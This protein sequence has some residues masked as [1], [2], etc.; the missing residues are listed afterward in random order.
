MTLTPEQIQANRK[1]A[2]NLA[3]TQ[4]GLIDKAKVDWSYDERTNYNKALAKIIKDSPTSFATQDVA[5]ASQVERADYSPLASADFS[6]S[7]F[8]SAV[9]DNVVDA[10]NS[11]AGIGKGV[12][13]AA[14][15]AQ[16][17]IPIAGVALLVFWLMGQ[18]RKLA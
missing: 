9:V 10:G 11:V 7:D 18:K 2:I 16:Y 6:F 5:T 4:T 17:A 14:K 8:G 12:L 3:L 15:L 1:S 13:S